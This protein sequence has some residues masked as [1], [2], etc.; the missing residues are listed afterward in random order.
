LICAFPTRPSGDIDAGDMRGA[1]PRTPGG[2]GPSYLQAKGRG[3]YTTP[4]LRAHHRINQFSSGDPRR[5]NRAGGQ[6]LRGYRP[7]AGSVSNPTVNWGRG[8]KRPTSSPEKLSINQNLTRLGVGVFP[9]WPK[10]LNCPGL[11]RGGPVRNGRGKLFYPHQKVRGK[12]RSGPRQDFGAE[13]SQKAGE[14]QTLGPGNRTLGGDLG[15][16]YWG[17]KTFQLAGPNGGYTNTHGPATFPR[18]PDHQVWNNSR[19]TSRDLEI[20]TTRAGLWTREKNRL[21]WFFRE[22]EFL[23]TKHEKPA[24]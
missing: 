11:D 1:P 21:T 4:P 16:P 6:K 15:G 18:T 7:E 20:T 12:T 3:D 19:K 22:S 8:G 10:A 2:G 17:H 13:K 24:S 23:G 9:H 5:R 14:N